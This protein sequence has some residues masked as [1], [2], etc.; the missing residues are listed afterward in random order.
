MMFWQKQMHTAPPKGIWPDVWKAVTIAIITGALGYAG[1][2]LLPP[3]ALYDR[4]FRQDPNDFD[5]TWI[6][7]FAGSPAKLELKGEPDPNRRLEGVLTIDYGQPNS[8]VIKVSGNHDSR[9]ILQGD[10]DSTRR[11]T[12]GLDRKV[13]ER[14]GADDRFVFLVPGDAKESAVLVCEK[15]KLN[16][17][18]KS[19]CQPLGAG[20]S[21]FARAQKP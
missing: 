14:F 11:L 16:I 10:W 4:W 2:L 6:G 17:A 3:G 18:A 7:E 13:G 8:R 12:I 21:F 19:E 20:R 9:V 1:G 15:G 5:G